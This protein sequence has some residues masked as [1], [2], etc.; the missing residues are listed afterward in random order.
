MKT[1]MPLEGLKVVELAAW[2]FVPATGGHLADMGAD[3]IKIERPVVG[4]PCRGV[5]GHIPA[6]DFNYTFEMINRNKKS[7]VLDLKNESARSIVHKLIEKSDV[8]ITNY[9]SNT[10]EEFNLDY[11]TLSRINPELIYGMGSGWGQ[12]GAPDP[13][14]NVFDYLAFARSG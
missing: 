9:K 5:M 12:H 4:D 2:V 1:I 11:D 10:L 8:F 6:S 3:V 13:D 14:E 7:I